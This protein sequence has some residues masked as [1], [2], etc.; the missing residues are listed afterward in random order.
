M[1]D[2]VRAEYESSQNVIKK[3]KA[4]LEIYKKQ[5]KHTI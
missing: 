1:L 4:E 3:M 2:N 5:Y